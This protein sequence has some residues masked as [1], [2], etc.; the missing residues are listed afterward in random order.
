MARKYALSELLQQIKDKK[1]ADFPEAVMSTQTGQYSRAEALAQ[2]LPQR[3][4]RGDQL[5]N[6][7]KKKG[8]T[9]EELRELGL[10]DLLKQDRVTQEELLRA[11][12][13]GRIDLEET[14]LVES[15]RRGVDQ[16][17]YDTE[18]LTIS[19]AHG[20]DYVA[21]EAKE[22]LKYDQELVFDNYGNA[23]DLEGTISFSLRRTPEERFELS[24]QLSNFAEG[25]VDFDDL[26]SDA[27]AWLSGEAKRLVEA[28]YDSDPLYRIS[29]TLPDVNEMPER[30]ISLIGNDD[31]G[32]SFA[33]N[34]DNDPFG[35]SVYLD[36]GIR[37]GFDPVYSESEAEIALY[38]LAEEHVED[39]DYDE[40]GGDLGHTK[41]GE[42][43]IQGGDNYR[44]FIIQADPGGEVKFDLGH[45]EDYPNVVAHYR[46][47]DR[48]G[49]NNEKIFFVEEIQ[50]DWAQQARQKGFKDP[51]S[52]KAANEATRRISDRLNEFIPYNKAGK[53]E[54]EVNA[55]IEAYDAS[56]TRLSDDLKQGRVALDYKNSVLNQALQDLRRAQGMTGR[57]SEFGDIEPWKATEIH[58]NLTAAKTGFN[59]YK[60][61]A[62]DD[63]KKAGLSP[64]QAAAQADSMFSDVL[65]RY[66]P[67]LQGETPI[68]IDQELE[69][70][71]G[72][73]DGQ[74]LRRF[75]D[76][77]GGLEKG[78]FVQ[79]SES[80]N[81]LVMKN[82]VSRATSEGY[83]KVAFA[84]PQAHI[85]RWGSRYKDAME[86]QYAVNVPKAVKSVTGQTPQVGYI[87][88][89][90]E[91]NPLTID[92]KT[93]ELQQR[94]EQGQS[95]FTP[96][97]VTVGATGVAAQMMPQ[98]SQA[99]FA[100]QRDQK[101]TAWTQL[102]DAVGGLDPSFKQ[103]S[104]LLSDT[105]KTSP[106]L[107]GQRQIGGFLANSLAGMGSGFMG[108][109]AYN[110]ADPSAM[111]Y[112]SGEQ[113]EGARDFVRGA[114]EAIGFGSMED[115][116]INQALMDAMSGVA[117]A[118]TDNDYYRAINTA[119]IEP[120]LQ[121]VGPDVLDW[122]EGLD[123]RA[124]GQLG[125]V[126]EYLSNAI[127]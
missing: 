55:D 46:V 14:E 89:M 42:Y 83:D 74:L 126:M 103:L 32:Y 99:S 36:E 41:Y 50:S 86:T 125:G 114:P 108:A 77:A 117:E 26:P 22:M 9:D 60:A 29:V 56:I 54:A 110:Q 82:L 73:K 39:F 85:D 18:T 31:F 72:S 3:K 49:P 8:V 79:D 81:K 95:L 111:D 24:K 127:R 109:A 15:A 90:A 93:P 92:L 116:L 5:R 64:E 84:P 69:A 37:D 106:M 10:D 112:F 68:R 1:G 113:I 87:P 70:I 23:G 20:D 100:T 45:Y 101:N 65:Q 12:D 121:D 124:Q 57:L 123:P 94:M 71:L 98:E 88:E 17:G 105:A 80:W 4:Q 47:T 53:T 35:D 52:I 28:N 11:I 107:E 97:A 38:R 48:V 21:S 96:A 76:T 122:Y 16:L 34:Y 104:Q 25:E 115:N 58:K 119:F 118:V 44:E 51:E 27:Q 67:S 43:R 91:Y 61:M 2:T 66:F 102:K 33:A 30:Q 19:E 63:A 78:P 120:A 59:S 62:L 13:E 75:P 6:F 40:G 7:L